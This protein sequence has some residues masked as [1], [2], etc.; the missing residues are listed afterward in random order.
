MAAA[1]ENVYTILG[2]GCDDARSDVII[3]AGSSYITLEVCGNVSYDLPKIIYAFNDPDVNQELLNPTPAA[4][5][6]LT[7]YF[8]I[9]D[10]GNASILNRHDSP[11]P[12]PNPYNTFLAQV[13]I[14]EF[15]G[16]IFK[17]G[18]YRKNNLPFINNEL[19]ETFI[20]FPP[21]RP[22]TREDLVEIY[23]GSLYQPGYDAIFSKGPIRD[24]STLALL[25]KL[26]FRAEYAG[27]LIN[28]FDVFNIN[29]IM[30]TMPGIYY[31]FACRTE[32]S[33]DAVA[34]GHAKDRSFRRIGIHP[35]NIVEKISPDN[36]TALL[37]YLGYWTSKKTRAV[38][39]LP[40]PVEPQWHSL[41]VAG[42]LVRV[43]QKHALRILKE[44]MIIGVGGRRIFK[45]KTKK[46]RNCKQKSK[47][48]RCLTKES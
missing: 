17:S 44:Q 38:Q 4:L 35:N 40:P 11:V 21:G 7:Q 19:G 26:A 43:A 48:S 47:S 2:H 3:P 39:G 5:V 15:G 42:M 24:V 8:S 34:A 23:R 41:M 46:R 14:G 33:G 6:R 27:S 20:H 31:N 9:S 16:V 30:A 13:D 37:Q 45:R 36:H 28:K 18:L 1:D 32:C 25:V 10:M 22:I 29:N 12:V